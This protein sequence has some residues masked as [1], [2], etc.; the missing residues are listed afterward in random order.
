MRIAA[1]TSIANA[2]S[3]RVYYLLIALVILFGLLFL[4]SRMDGDQPLKPMEAP[5]V[6]A[7]ATK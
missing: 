5:V 3:R 4:L 6:Q 1:G 2:M 7:A